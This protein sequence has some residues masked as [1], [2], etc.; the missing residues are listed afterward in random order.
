MKQEMTFQGVFTALAT[1]FDGGAIAWEDFAALLERQI[2]GGVAGVVPAGTTGESPTVD[3]AEHIELIRRT[4]EIVAGRIPVVAGTGANSTAEALEL[5]RA[6]DQCG[7]DAH[8]QV[9]PY[10]NKPTQE[11]LFQHFSAVAGATDKPILLY[12]IP[13]RS[14]VEIGI[15]TVVRLCESFPN[16]RALKEASGQSERVSECVRILGDRCPVLSG[17]DSQT[18]PFMAIGATGVVSVASNLLPGKIAAL[19]AAFAGGDLPRARA[20]H[21]ELFPLFRDLFI[22]ANPA[23]VKYALQRAGI[24]RRDEVR[25]PLVPLSAEARKVLDQRLEA[26]GICPV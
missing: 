10:Y 14:V 18:L 21:S 24:F 20:L 16:I 6:A 15:H 1:P 17:D 11:G 12:S 22:E 26:L 13:G 7:V 9:C 23:P 8:L 4:V 3:F 2:S 5:V 25:L 19:V